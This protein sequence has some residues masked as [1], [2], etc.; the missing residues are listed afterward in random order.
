[1]VCLF[2]KSSFFAGLWPFSIS[3]HLLINYVS[4]RNY[5]IFFVDFHPI[6]LY[7]LCSQRSE[8]PSISSSALVASSFT[9][10]HS[11]LSLFFSYQPPLPLPLK[12]MPP[13]PALSSFINRPVGSQPFSRLVRLVFLRVSIHP[14]RFLGHP[15]SAVLLV[16]CFFFFILISSSP[17]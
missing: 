8:S 11:T 4:Q 3:L 12:S 5:L 6:A 13:N 10:I 1:M 2:S 7:F 17:F 15:S 14:A 16:A 9:P